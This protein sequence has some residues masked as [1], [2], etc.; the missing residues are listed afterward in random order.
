MNVRSDFPILRN[1]PELIYL[2]SSSTSLV[3]D[4]AIE[5]TEKFMKHTLVSSRRGAYKLAV[6]GSRMV[7]SV[8]RALATIL[9]TDDSRISFQKSIASAA[10]SFAYGYDWE[11][12]QKNKVVVAESE[13]HNVFV[14]LLR[15]SQVLDLEFEVIP[16][17][18]DGILN[19]EDIGNAIDKRTG[20]VAVSHV[21]PGLGNINPLHEISQIAEENNALL[22][23]DASRSIG[24]I[25]FKIA[26]IPADIILFSANIGFLGPPG[27]ALQCQTSDISDDY[28]P[29]IVGGSAVTEVGNESFRTSKSPH[30]FESDT[31]NLPAIAGLGSAI[32]Y[33]QR[34][35]VDTV[36]NSNRRLSRRVSKELHQNEH[37]SLYGENHDRRTIFGFNISGGDEINCHDVALFLDQAAIA[38]RTGYVCAHPSIQKIAPNGLIQVSIHFYNTMKE[39]ARLGEILLSISE[40]L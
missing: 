33:L 30:K 8:R 21:T 18:D 29:G 4:A 17:D 23:T 7:D 13:E 26:D 36:I 11:A 31:L 6:D 15:V 27:L 12:S 37:I 3:P 16:V 9:K 20:I 28:V 38:V 22:L 2:D 32:E 19:L 25:E 40:M 39:I 24:F 34:I 14:S 1:Y 5:A 10:A 35:G